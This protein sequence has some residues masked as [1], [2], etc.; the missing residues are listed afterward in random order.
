MAA[1]GVLAATLRVVED[2]DVE[3]LQRIDTV[4]TAFEQ[5]IGGLRWLVKTLQM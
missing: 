4:E 1:S 2:L 3:I 5:K